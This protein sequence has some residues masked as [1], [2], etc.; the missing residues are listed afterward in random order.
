M[1]AKPAAV[2]RVVQRQVIDHQRNT[3]EV[4][5]TALAELEDTPLSPH[6]FD[7]R[8]FQ[9]QVGAGG[10]QSVRVMRHSRLHYPVKAVA[11]QK[12]EQAGGDLLRVFPG[13]Q[14]AHELNENAGFIRT[15]H[16]QRRKILGSLKLFT[17]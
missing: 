7:H 15:G 17:K 8:N 2:F 6:M 3:F 5:H 14:L 4:V 9:R 10:T 12:F 1:V 16:H 11:L 13:D